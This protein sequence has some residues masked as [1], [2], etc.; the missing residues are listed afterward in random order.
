[1]AHADVDEES[2]RID[3]YE[4]ASC[5][6]SERAVG[7]LLTF[8]IEFGYL[9]AVLRGFRSGFLNELQ[10]R[11]LCQ[12]ENLDDVKMTLGDTDYG[13]VIQGSS[14]RSSCSSPAFAQSNR[15]QCGFAEC[16]VQCACCVVPG[17]KPVSF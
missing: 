5:V 4:E 2:R 6:R 3:F 8:N 10:Y 13:S 7:G 1:M 16:I 12:C 14:A 9:E 15:I 11:Q 17:Q